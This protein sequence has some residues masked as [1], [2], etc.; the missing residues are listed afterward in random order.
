VSRPANVRRMFG[1]AKLRAVGWREHG[2][3]WYPPWP[4]PFSYTFGAAQLEQAQAR[5]SRARRQ[6]I[7]ELT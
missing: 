6:R 3:Q 2:A 4:S 1:A 5:S 7:K